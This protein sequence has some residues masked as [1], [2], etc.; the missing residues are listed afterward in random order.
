MERACK[1]MQTPG[2]ERG[3]SQSQGG[4]L[5][6]RSDCLDR[7][8]TS[9]THTLAGSWFTGQPTGFPVA[10]DSNSLCSQLFCS[11]PPLFCTLSS[12]FVI[13]STLGLPPLHRPL[14]SSSSPPSSQCL[15]ISPLALCFVSIPLPPLLNF[16][17]SLPLHHRKPPSSCYCY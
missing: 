14:P 15:H 10:T 13:L 3:Q 5:R 7:A 4:G 8:Q 16:H 11:S 2:E 12:C 17:P 9:T 1:V 6:R